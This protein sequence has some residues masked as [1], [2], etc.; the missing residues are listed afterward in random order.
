MPADRDAVLAYLHRDP[1]LNLQLLDLIDKDPAAKTAADIEPVVLVAWREDEIVGVA[2][3]RPSLLFDAHLEAPAL[4]AF[5]PFFGM[6]ETGLLK[7]IDTVV[8]ELWQLL[9]STGRRALIDRC[10]LAFAIRQGELQP[11]SLPEGAILRHA[12]LGDLEEL[13]YAARA[14]LREE[15]RPD[16][17]ERDP[18]GFGRWVRSRV[19]RARVVQIDGRLAFVG[20]ADVRRDEGWLVQ[21]VFT[22]PAMRRGG[23]A[24]AAMSGLVQEAFEAGAEH[25]QLAVVEGNEPALSLYRRLGFE[26]FARLRTVLFVGTAA[27]RAR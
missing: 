25:V 22:W 6:I 26:S 11:A 8:S 14:S 3:L 16:P 18:V 23:L 2:S 24:A 10:E 17:G 21:G 19:E 5:L 20:Y 4:A 15:Q 9:E 27:G 7:T 1:Q 12:E 13:I